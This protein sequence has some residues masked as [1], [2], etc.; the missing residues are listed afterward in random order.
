MNPTLLKILVICRL[1]RCSGI[2]VV[3]ENTRQT[4]LIFIQIIILYKLEHI[5]YKL[6]HIL[7]KLEQIHSNRHECNL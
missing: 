5:L 7:Y 2:R 1:L 3:D 6:E 4:S